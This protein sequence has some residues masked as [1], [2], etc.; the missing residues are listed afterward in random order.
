MDTSRTSISLQNILLPKVGICTEEQMFFRRD[1]IPGRDREVVLSMTD[2]TLSFKKDGL[3]FFDT[4]FNAITVTK[5]KKYTNIG[6]ITLNLLLKGDFEVTLRNTDDDEMEPSG[7]IIGQSIVGSKEKKLFTFPCK[8]YEYKGLLHFSLRALSEDSVFFGGWYASDVE[9]GNLIDTN[10]AINICT[11]K[12]E[13][14]V[15][16]NIDILKKYIIGNPDSPLYGH[17]QVYISDN[18]KTLPMDELNDDTIHI[19][20]NKNV[21]GAGGFTRG[22]IEIMSHETDFP[23]THA[24]MMDD[25]V[26]I[27]PEAIFR[28]FALLRCRKEQYK[29]MFIGGAMLR[30][31]RQNVQEESGASWNAGDL[32]SNKSGLD[33]NKIRNVLYNEIEE[34]T[35]YNAWW[36]CCTPMSVVS[37]RNLPLP[38]F[39]RG[40]DLEFGLRNMKT[41]VLM[42][43]ICVWHEPFENKYSSYLYYYILRN[44]LY[45]NTVHFKDYSAMS[46]L[47]RMYGIALREILYYR[48]K[49]VDLLFRG[50]NDYL[51]GSKFLSETDGEKL[52]KDILASGY[53][54]VPCEQLAD[55]ALHLPAYYD[56]L[57]E[58]EGKIH[59][60]FRLLSCNG[61]LLPAKKLRTKREIKAVSMSQC[62][63]I[64]FFRHSK[65]VN[66]DP[67]SGKAFVTE[68]SYKEAFRSVLGLLVITFKVLAGY[69]RAKKDFQDNYCVFTGAEFW[70]DYLGL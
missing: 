50:V 19:V 26:V 24:L 12:R 23:A 58:S 48:Y 57:S 38:I 29:D 9:D 66:Y 61:Y 36:Y 67:A 63:P 8:L 56:S 10:I 7:R 31:D 70:D 64:N 59:R 32:V 18:G 62:R 30:L 6:D 13:P 34:C 14:F 28:T 44:L 16:R 25:D 55:V 27:E 52:H 42:N 60:L 41:L 5:W 2:N 54:A 45:D 11:F 40:D 21:G 4:Y 46:L 51:K 22:L 65:V 17:V 53:K 20:Q 43:G 37:P 33:L 39:I 69:N 68:R 47:K 35:E 49:N 15:K 3:C 1:S